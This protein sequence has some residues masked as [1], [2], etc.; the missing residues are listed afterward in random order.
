MLRTEPKD[1][2]ADVPGAR[3]GS[4]WKFRIYENIPITSVLK[5]SEPP[6]REMTLTVDGATNIGSRLSSLSMRPNSKY[7]NYSSKDRIENERE[8]VCTKTK[9]L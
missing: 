9:L 4:I 2:F 8:R 3:S 6:E 5:V 1:P 7:Q